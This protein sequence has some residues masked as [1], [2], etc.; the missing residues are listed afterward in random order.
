MGTVLVLAVVVLI[1]GGIIWGM[2]KK[3]KAGKGVFCNC[4]S[5]DCDGC[6]GKCA[7]GK[8]EN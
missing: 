4:G 8:K 5:D 1:V 2:Y 7:A 3:K 6:G